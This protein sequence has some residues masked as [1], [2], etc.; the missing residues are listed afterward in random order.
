MKPKN[1]VLLGFILVKF[2]LQYTLINPVYELHRDEYLHLDQARHLDWGYSSVPPF[3]S[4]ISWIILQLGNSEFWVKFFPALF[5]ALTLVVVW[6]T[7]EAL[8]GGWFALILGSVSVVFSTLIRI[9]MLYQ[10]NSF[11]VL[12]W[13]LLFFTVTKFIQSSDNKWL[14]YAGITFAFGFLNKYNI[15]FLM[16]GLLPSILITEHRSLFRNKQLYYALALAFVLILPN[17]IWQYLN[18]F[19]VFKHL[20]ELARTQLVNVN[21]FDFLKEQLLFFMGSLFIILASFVA[22]IIYP[23]FRKFRIIGWTFLF[24]IALFTYLKAKGYYAIG[25]YPILLAFGSVYLEKILDGPR[26]KYVRP[27]ALLIPLFM[28]LPMLQIAFPNRTP[29]EIRQH[30]KQYRDFGLLRWEDGKEHELP[31]DFADMQGWKELA[32]KVDAAFATIPDREHTL[33]LCDN[34]GQAGAINYY[35]VNK[36]TGAVSM[37]ADYINWFRLDRE[38]RNVILIQEASDTDPERNK[39]KPYFETIER[40]G[41]ITNPYAREKGTS[42]YVMKN[43]KVDINEILRKEIAEKKS[44]K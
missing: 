35:S 28:F 29:Q 38:I 44:R 4:W 25:L 41:E 37:N 26:I 40:V 2:V 32:K 19:P 7:I 17:L 16:I 43:A 36:N 20:D 23:P 42:I 27:V 15:A 33:I 3:T 8:K 18:G 22:F 30:E 31:Q 12:V 6:K 39:E 14:W 11:D 9:N 10:P 34:Y 5:G 24:I 21:R 1:L 13:T